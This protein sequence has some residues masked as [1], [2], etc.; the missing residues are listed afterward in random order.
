LQFTEQDKK[1]IPILKKIEFEQFSTKNRPI[2]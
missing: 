2:S 1:V